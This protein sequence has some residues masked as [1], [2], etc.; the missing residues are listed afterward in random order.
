MASPV[1]IPQFFAFTN[2]GTY[3]IVFT[4]SNPGG[5]VAVTNSSYITVQ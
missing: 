1:N 3:T 5:S 4:T 2:A